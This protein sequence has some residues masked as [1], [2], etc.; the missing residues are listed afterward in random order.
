M[1]HLLAVSPVS[2][3]ITACRAFDWA[4]RA[5]DDALGSDIRKK[6]F[7]IAAAILLKPAVMPDH[8]HLGRYGGH[9]LLQGGEFQRFI[10]L[11]F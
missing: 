6:K 10:H 9:F 1:R 8:P 7:T 3:S 5:A 11:S 2:G 4:W